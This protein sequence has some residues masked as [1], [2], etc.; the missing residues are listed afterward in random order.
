MKTLSL[1]TALS[2]LTSLA[3]AQMNQTVRGTIID[4]DS[5][6]PLIGATIML[7]GSDPIKG[8]STDV[9]GNFR[10]TEVP[11][12]RAAFQLSY[13][14]YES[15]TISN[16]VV[17]SGKEVI[18][19]LSM[20]ESIIKMDEIVIT[21]NEVQGRPTNEMA[22]LSARS[23]SPEE[24]KR[25]PGIFN[26]PSRVVSRFAGV[27]STQDG[28]ND[29][30]VRGNSPK[31]VH[32]RLEGI[33]ITNP[34][35]FGDP[36]TAGGAISTLNNNMLAR[37][38]F[39]TGAFAPEFGDALSAVYDLKL[40]AG[41]NE[42]V[43]GVAGIGLLGTDLTLEGPFKKGYGG[44]FAA[45]Y[46]YSSISLIDALGLV[47]IKGIPKFQDASFKLTF[48]A[49][50]AGVFSLFGLGGY[51]E[52]LFED[53]T[54]DVW[55][56]PGNR[57]QALNV[58]EDYEKASHLINT[59][60]SHSINLNKNSYINSTLLY[61]NEGISDNIFESNVLQITDSQGQ[62]LRDSVISRIQNF[63]MELIKSSYRVATTFNHKFNARNKIEIGTKYARFDY[64]IKQSQLA[65]LSEEINE[66][67]DFNE[68]ISTIRNFVSWR[69]KLSE[70]LT[71]VAGVHNV[72]V[73][74]NNKYTIEPRIAANW[75]IDNRQA[76][77]VGF[78]QHSTM[79]S[80]HHY[81]SRIEQP[82][83]TF[84]QPNLDLDLLKARH[85]V[86]GYEN[87]LTQNMR[88]SLE[89]YYQD[90]YSLPVENND[91]S[92]FATI[93]E[94][95]EF[96]LV[97]L[98]NEGTGA[99]YGVELTLERFFHNNYYFL[100]NGSVYQSK[101]K[102]LENV[103]RNTSYNSNFLINFLIGKEWVGLGK[104]RNQILS[105]NANVFFGGARKIIPL[106]RDDDGNL[107]VDPENNQ[108][109]DYS[110]AYENGLDNIF[111][112]TVSGTYKW[113]KPKSTHELVL[114][115]N[116]ISNSLGRISE[117]YDDNQPGNIGY[118]TQFEFFPNLMY[119]VYF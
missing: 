65:D 39:Y 69:H 32:W 84:T 54:P 44:S 20:E 26:D 24:T 57:G 25:F 91:T 76:I 106:L 78:G 4:S 28:S 49:K 60:L 27:T 5:N 55:E 33:Q 16:I 9:E 104:K 37:S 18:L 115:L 40:R 7:I 53:V 110:K 102:T 62:P 51:S 29:I 35:H 17:D 13:L 11:L 56:T 101:Y 48:P 63:D 74:L 42:K 88:L 90:L 112:T 82:D 71:I 117:Y 77:K 85:Y 2:F 83:G 86:L 79:E 67:L 34:N 73:L 19:D 31:Y 23:V 45:N 114:E 68:N 105:V 81:F 15:K 94:G 70:D 72:N 111:Q 80:V 50:K 87:Q 119:R 118:L 21:A 52:F 96:T 64:K 109:K 93:N 98:V 58:K 46:R 3:F 43:E 108:F 8:S 116:N 61:S 12:G 30:I 75:Q 22:L 10:I 95:L 47:D 38:D 103:E 36:N 113:N 1:A 89:L 6:T 41:N 59:G 92:I 107:N 66:G 14:G 99:N 100:I 97:D